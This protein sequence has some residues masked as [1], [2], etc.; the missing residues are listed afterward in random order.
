MTFIIPRIFECPICQ[1]RMEWTPSYGGVAA[2]NPAGL[3][4]PICPTC[5]NKWHQSQGWM[6]EPVN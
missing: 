3:A 6:M 2:T 1:K 4:R 5:I